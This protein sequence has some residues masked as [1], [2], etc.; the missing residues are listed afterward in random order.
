M[1]SSEQL[2]RRD[3]LAMA[4]L[5]A[6]FAGLA[7]GKAQAAAF[8]DAERANMHTV[9]DFCAAWS[10][11][12]I[13]KISAFFADDAVYRVIETAKPTVG[14]PAIVKLLSMFVQQAQK[15]E[16]HAFET[17]AAGPIVLNRRRDSFVSAR[18]SRSF[19]VAGVFFLR[20]GKIAEWTDY[21]VK[22]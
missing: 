9:K 1:A 17:Y 7:S 6:A 5:G 14:K 12:D 3:L 20:D 22:T 10:T 15:V 18:G 4:G 19:E 21:T 11:R 13:D 8:T 16:F 2:R